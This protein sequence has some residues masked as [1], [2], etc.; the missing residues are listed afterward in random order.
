M[1]DTTGLPSFAIACEDSIGSTQSY[2]RHA[3]TIIAAIVVVFVFIVFDFV[4]VVSTMDSR[5]SSHDNKGGYKFHLWIPQVVSTFG[6][7]P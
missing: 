5:L 4:G 3:I 6:I 1:S 2:L 7:R